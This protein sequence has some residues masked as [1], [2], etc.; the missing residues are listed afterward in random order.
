ML[1]VEQGLVNGPV[2]GVKLANSGFNG[3]LEEGDIS[4]G[5]AGVLL[6]LCFQSLVLSVWGLFL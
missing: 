6:S 2:R 3:F 1:T 4:R 5:K